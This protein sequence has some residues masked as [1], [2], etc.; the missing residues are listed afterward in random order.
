ML[1]MPASPIVVNIPTKKEIT[2]NLENNTTLF[3]LHLKFSA[4]ITKTIIH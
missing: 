1:I 4:L 2:T 3:V